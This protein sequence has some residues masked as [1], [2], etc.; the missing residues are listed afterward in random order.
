MKTD[1][2]N[3]AVT[4]LLVILAAFLIPVVPLLGMIVAWLAYLSGTSV[5]SEDAMISLLA[6]V[7]AIGVGYSIAKAIWP[8][9]P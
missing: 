7:S 2:G 1:R 5:R 6:V 4:I 3:L 8:T 9:L